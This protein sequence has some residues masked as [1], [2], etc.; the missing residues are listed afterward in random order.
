MARILVVDDDA[1]VR[2]SFSRL[3]RD[4]GHEVLTAASLEEGLAM[5]A[6]GVDL[7]YLDLNLPDGEGVRAIDDLVSSPGTPEVIAITGMGFG[8]GAQQTIES[9]AWDYITKPASPQV[10]RQSLE[11]VLAYRRHAYADKP[12][13]VFDRCGII[14]DS[15]SMQRIYNDLDKAS[16][17]EATVLLRG[18]TGVGKELAAHAIHQNSSRKDGPFIVVDCSSLTASLIE[19]T[20]YGHVKGAFTDARSD[21]TGLIAA[22]DGGTLFLDE[23]GELPPS[24][25]KSFL[26]VLQERRFR[27]VGA[28]REQSSDFR[29]VAAT[30]RD[31]ESMV[32][33]GIFRSDVL[34][35]IRAVEIVLPPLKE[36]PEDFEFL[37]AHFI[38][39]TSDR[40][41][42]EAKTPSEELL[43]VVRSYGWPGNI[44]EL[45][46]VIESAV[47]QS[48]DGPTIYPKHLPNHI[49]LAFIGQNC[50]PSLGPERSY[51]ITAQSQSQPLQDSANTMAVIQ[52]FNVYKTTRDREYF[53]AL[54]HTTGRDVSRASQLSGLSIPTVYRYL[55]QF[56]LSSKGDR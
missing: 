16:R 19:S 29:L 25:Q 33:K 34:Y 24:L 52:P 45:K 32:R 27:P 49:R 6:S 56:G 18:E 38:R 53:K 44:R 17:T 36:R 46:N 3:F 1:L 11:S 30:N 51:G 28:N 37:V 47:I 22:A 48:G 10:I 54:I 8:Y 14:G 2:N 20:L 55:A 5:A 31:L 43:R 4:E 13:S 7:V 12:V 35:R 50:E 42:F 41:G 39:Q 23:I 40:Y 9:K 26:R 15:P 21:R